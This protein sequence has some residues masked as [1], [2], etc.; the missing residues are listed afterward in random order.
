[1]GEQARAGKVVVPIVAIGAVCI[2]ALAQWLQSQAGGRVGRRGKSHQSSLGLRHA[3]LT[4]AE[5]RLATHIM[6]PEQVQ[7]LSEDD[8]I[9]H[10]HIVKQLR[11][12]IGISLRGAGRS[13]VLSQ[14]RGFLI[15]GPPG[16]GKT[17]IA[18]VCVPVHGIGPRRFG[19]IQTAIAR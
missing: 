19:V 10:Q 12:T 18:E 3:R 4:A 14:G 5:R 2:F 6:D 13:S 8:I 7:K 1:M 15:S 11:R 16:T 17:T 9:G